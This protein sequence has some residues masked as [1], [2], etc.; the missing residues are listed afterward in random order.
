M[1]A[2]YK[3]DLQDWV[4]NPSLETYT[5]LCNDINNFNGTKDAEATSLILEIM[6][7][8]LKTDLYFPYEEENIY[9][10]SLDRFEDKI[11]FPSKDSPYYKNI[12]TFAIK[13]LSIFK[14]EE[15]DLDEDQLYSVIFSVVEFF[16]G[17]KD[18]LS[19]SALYHSLETIEKDEWLMYNNELVNLFVEI[20]LQTGDDK[21]GIATSCKADGYEEYDD[22]YYKTALFLH[23][24]DI[25]DFSEIITDFDKFFKLYDLLKNT[26]YSHLLFDALTGVNFKERCYYSNYDE[27][28]PWLYDKFKEFRNNN[29]E[30]RLSQIIALALNQIK[31]NPQKDEIDKEFSFEIFKYIVDSPLPIY[32]EWLKMTNQEQYVTYDKLY[33]LKTKIEN[34]DYWANEVAKTLLKKS[35]YKEFLKT[36]SSYFLDDPAKNSSNPEPKTAIPAASENKEIIESKPS[37][38]KKAAKKLLT[39]TNKVKTTKNAYRPKGIKGHFYGLYKLI[40]GKTK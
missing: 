14:Q 2:K 38:S 17:E 5:S 32:F 36:P 15:E 25:Y 12:I 23:L 33:Y 11:H 26:P 9:Q 18:N 31:F 30:S 3:Q 40:H 39:S 28:V 20:A 37:K 8:V 35:S 21:L 10:L 27:F 29:D 1:V 16:V 24:G 19:A 6:L 7:E 13:L 4:Y 22:L 34:D